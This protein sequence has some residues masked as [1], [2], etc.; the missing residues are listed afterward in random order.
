MLPIVDSTREK[1]PISTTS[2]RALVG[3]EFPNIE[4]RSSNYQI[5][6]SIFCYI[7]PGASLFCGR[8]AEL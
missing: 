7:K 1:V 2:D 6:S 5:L 8:A 4:V 3:Y